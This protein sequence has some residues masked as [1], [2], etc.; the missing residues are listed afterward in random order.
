MNKEIMYPQNI[1]DLFE[2]I[3]EIVKNE[4]NFEKVTNINNWVNWFKSLNYEFKYV[5]AENEYLKIYYHY[6]KYA[7]QIWEH[8]DDIDSV[9]FDLVSNYYSEYDNELTEIIV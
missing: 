8:N 7:L 1:K 4:E 6:N 9:K 2:K 5:C 3:D